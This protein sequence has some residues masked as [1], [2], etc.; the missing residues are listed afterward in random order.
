MLINSLL[1]CPSGKHG[2]GK[3]F[4]FFYD[5]SFIVCHICNTLRILKADNVYNKRRIE[6]L[7][8]Q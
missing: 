1:W 7:P 5:R 4:F 3:L 6:S 8:A 2:D